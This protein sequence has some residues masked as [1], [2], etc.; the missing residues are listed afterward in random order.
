MNYHLMNRDVFFTFQNNFGYFFNI[1]FVN[2]LNES[3]NQSNRN[4]FNFFNS[5]KL[6]KNLLTKLIS[7]FVQREM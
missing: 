1:I 2:R 6:F 7:I 4:G 3:P 5:V